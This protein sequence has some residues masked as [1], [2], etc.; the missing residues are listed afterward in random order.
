[1]GYDRTRAGPSPAA[2]TARNDEITARPANRGPASTR[3]AADEDGRT[4]Q[5]IC[6][7]LFWRFSLE[8]APGNRVVRTS[9]SWDSIVVPD[10]AAGAAHE[11]RC[12]TGCRDK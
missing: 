2:R 8:P 9:L 5:D 3:D 12:N 11:R 4:D 10:F 1:M 7:L 6:A